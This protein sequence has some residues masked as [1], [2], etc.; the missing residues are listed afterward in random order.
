MITRRVARLLRFGKSTFARSHERHACFIS[1][2]MFFLEHGFTL[3]GYV[4][5]ISLGGILFRPAQSYVVRRSAGTVRLT[6]GLL[7]AEAELRN[8]SALGYGL[9]LRQ[10]LTQEQLAA[11]LA[12]Q[13]TSSARNT[14]NYEQGV[15]A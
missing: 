6:A 11:I 15:H 5:E 12:E 9:Q 7:V 4:E 3:D 10:T 8:T 1:G 13:N 2:T 14:I